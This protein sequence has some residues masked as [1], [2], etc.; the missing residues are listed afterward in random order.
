MGKVVGIDLGTTNSLVAYVRDGA[1]RVIRDSSG[2]ALVPSVVSLGD[3]GTIFVGREAQRRLLT[4]PSRTVYSVKRFMGRGIEDVR[5]EAAFLP[6]QISGPRDESRTDAGGVVRIGLGERHFTPPEI[7]AFVLRELKQRAEE[8]FREQGEFDFEV[9]RAVITVPAYFNDAQRTATRDAGRLAGLEVLRIISEPTAASLA[10]GLDKKNRGT[11]AV[12]DLGGGTFDISILKV[13][14]GVFQAL[15]TSGDTHLGGD[16]IDHTLIELVLREVGV[17]QA[18]AGGMQ[19]RPDAIPGETI[20]AIRKAVIQAKWDLSDHERAEIRVEPQAGLPSGYR[21]AIT[22][23]EF[24]A[25]IRPF[26]DRTLGPVR[27]ALSDAGLEPGEVDEVVLVG[28]ATR[29]PLVRRL[30]AELFGRTPHS[31]LNPDEVVALGA[32]VQAD[33]LVSGR[34]EM[35]LLDVTPLSLGIETIGGVVSKIIMRNSTIPASGREMYTTSVDNQTSVDIHVVQGERELVADCRS[36][37]RFKLRG[38]PPMPAGLPRV[39]VRFQIDANGILSVGARELRTGVE[40][41]IEVKPSYGLTDQEVE[42]MLIESFEHAQADFDARLLIEAR[43]EAESVIN[44]TEKSLRR[45]D[46]AAV[47]R[48]ELTG[49]EIAQIE[50]TLAEL[51]QAMA[52]T[53]R[54]VIHEK[55]H[56]LNHATRHLAE[57]MMNRSVREALAGRNVEDI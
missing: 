10:Y 43:N 50:H 25:L 20:Q 56:A 26:V 55:T 33:I 18:G 35:L 57:V 32:A 34:R 54:E 48:D 14:D 40:Q 5:G 15:A 53:D 23:D 37:A 51:K 52:G 31:D 28:G 6:F 21:R 22:R 8:H 45:P 47:T 1:P 44:A 4:A 7:S 29:T 3:D 12:Y 9:D 13:E 49:D 2:D 42:R 11:I 24:E 39:E 27:Q 19:D 46:F 41:S 30:V 16:D 38:I 36:L 17:P